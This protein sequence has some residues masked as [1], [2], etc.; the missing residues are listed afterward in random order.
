[1]TNDQLSHLKPCPFCGGEAEWCHH[2]GDPLKLEDEMDG[3]HWIECVDCGTSTNLRYSLMDDCRPLLAEQ[4]NR[5]AA[6]EATAAQQDGWVSVEDRLP[7]PGV[8]VLAFFRNKLGK[9]RTVRAHHA[10][11]HTIEA[12]H[13]D[14]D[15][16][17]DDTEDGS[18]EPEGWYEDPAVGETMAFI[19]P[20]SDGV[21]THWMPLPAAPANGEGAG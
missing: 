7:G 19:S 15:S 21:V 8:A 6:S 10:P 4:W 11:K 16:E 18:F 2:E 9:R 20:E 14:D 17:T 12:G 5:R 13:W 1:M 3:A